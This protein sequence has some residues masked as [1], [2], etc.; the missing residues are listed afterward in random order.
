MPSLYDGR[1]FKAM[2]N[3]L[4]GL[5][6]NPTWGSRPAIE[7]FDLMG[8]F[9]RFFRFT[10]VV[11][12]FVLVAALILFCSEM[13]SKRGTPGARF[14]AGARATV[15]TYVPAVAGSVRDAVGAC[16]Q[17]G[18]AT[19]GVIDPD[20]VDC[21]AAGS[22]M[23]ARAYQSAHP[24]MA[25]ASVQP[26]LTQIRVPFPPVVQARAQAPAYAAP[27]EPQIGPVWY[28]GGRPAP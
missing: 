26:H 12:A 19:A 8:D 11:V 22:Q 10:G 21:A 5:G 9:V 24:K 7:G 23:V 3:E 20:K 13:I 28:G 4:L 2:H 15:S 27:A 6:R 14:L 17:D 16:V 1:Q 25:R 18:V